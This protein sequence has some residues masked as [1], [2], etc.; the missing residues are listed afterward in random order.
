MLMA[1]SFV[2]DGYR[3]RLRADRIRPGYRCLPASVHVRGAR[4][5]ST[6]RPATEPG[7]PL[8]AGGRPL[9]GPGWATVCA[10]GLVFEPMVALLVQKRRF[11]LGPFEFVSGV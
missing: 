8:A 9:R 10:G 4:R 11:A 1:D 5:L 3:P 2:L 7:K 6:T